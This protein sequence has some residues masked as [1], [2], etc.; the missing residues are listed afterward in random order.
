MRKRRIDNKKAHSSAN[1][2]QLLNSTNRKVKQYVTEH[3]GNARGGGSVGAYGGNNPSD[4]D[5]GKLRR[6]AARLSG[7]WKAFIIFSALVVLDYVLTVFAIRRHFS[8]F[9]PLTVSIYKSFQNPE[10]IFFLF[11]AFVIGLNGFLIYLMLKL[12]SQKK[13]FGKITLAYILLASVFAFAVVVYDIG[14][15][16]GVLA[17]PEF[18]NNFI[19]SFFRLFGMV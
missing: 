1:I 6:D 16:T 10:L 18:A 9:N 14:I 7:T 12:K 3:E 5:A 4:I 13:I 2:T 11:K 19:F 17:L 15:I 8:E